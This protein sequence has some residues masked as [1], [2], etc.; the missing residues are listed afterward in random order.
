MAISCTE[1]DLSRRHLSDNTLNSWPSD[2]IS[3]PRRS[4]ANSCQYALA[5]SCNTLSSKVIL[6]L[7]SMEWVYLGSDGTPSLFIKT[8][9]SVDTQIH[10]AAVQ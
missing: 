5:S 4:L 10:I 2:G 8:E 3:N 7:L 6:V 9:A 1:F